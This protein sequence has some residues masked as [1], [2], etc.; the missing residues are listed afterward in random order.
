MKLLTII[1]LLFVSLYCTKET[2]SPE[3]NM[4]D[5][6]INEMVNPQNIDPNKPLETQGVSAATVKNT[7]NFCKDTIRSKNAEIKNYQEKIEDLEDE[8]SDLKADLSETKE[9]SGQ[10]DLL[11]KILVFVVLGFAAYL[12]LQFL[13]IIKKFFGGI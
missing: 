11:N 13:P 6:V 2:P 9:K 7:L 8:I 10:V 4:V 1:L 5:S 3:E 12:L